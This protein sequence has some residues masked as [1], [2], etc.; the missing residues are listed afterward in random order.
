MAD[1]VKTPIFYSD[2]G[3]SRSLLVSIEAVAHLPG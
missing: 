3:D 1:L 2:V